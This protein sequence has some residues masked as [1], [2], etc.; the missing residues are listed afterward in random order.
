MLMPLVAYSTVEINGIYYELD[1]YTKT[2][3][4]SRNASGAYYG[5]IEIWIPSS[6]NYDGIDYKVTGIG[7]W[8]FDNAVQLTSITIPESVTYIEESAFYNCSSLTS[9]TIPSKVHSIYDNAF[10]LCSKLKN[11]IIPKSVT[12][13]GQSIF[14]YC[15]NLESIIV[16]EG[17]PKYD[18]RDNCNAIIW[19]DRLITGCKNTT[20]PNSVRC[21]GGWAFNNCTGLASITIP[22]SVTSIE[23][24]AFSG[25]TGLTSITIP[26]S[27]TSIGDYA[28]QACS[29]LTSITIGN[30]VTSIG[31][32]AF[33]ICDNLLEVTSK[34][35][36]PF[37]ISENT[38]SNNTFNN[39]TIYVPAE[40]INMYK[41]KEGW[42]KFINIQAIRVEENVPQDVNGDGIVDTQDVLEIYKYIQ[43]H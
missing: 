2:A 7:K 39:A 37:D 42:K 12:Y 18:S 38:F 3:K 9:I 31:S 35:E 28:F 22:N 14:A 34:I 25:C 32:F 26:N 6:I 19:D 10:Y 23:N 33:Y 4:V 20:I 40:T 16:E 21:I 8:A 15:G 24:G 17:N 5:R 27:V 36:N 29:G 13:I 11:I 1:S 41:T 30:S 43:E